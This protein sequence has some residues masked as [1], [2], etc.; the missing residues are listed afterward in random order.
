M[1]GLGDPN[2]DATAHAVIL[3]HK[4]YQPTRLVSVSQFVTTATAELWATWRR[5]IATMADVKTLVL[6][7]Y[8]LDTCFAWL[9]FVAR[10]EGR[11]VSAATAFDEAAWVSYVTAWEQGKFIDVAV[12]TSPA[13]LFTQLSHALLPKPEEDPGPGFVRSLAV[14]Q[15]LLD[16][17]PAPP[18][19]GIP[20]SFD[21]ELHR[22]AVA[23]I[24]FER[25]Q[26][27]AALERG[28]TFQLLLPSSVGDRTIIVDALAL[29][30]VE[31]TEILKT[32]ARQ[33][34]E[35]SWTRRGFTL[36]ALYR[37][38]QLHGN[39]MTVSVDPARYVTLQA[40]WARL[41]AMEDD[42]WGSDRPRDRPRRLESYKD[43]LGAVKAGAPNEPWY[44]EDARYTLIAAP[45]G[46]GSRLDWY[47]DVLP[48]SWDLY[49]LRHVR[50]RVR[51]DRQGDHAGKNITVAVWLSADAT[52]SSEVESQQLLLDAPS[53][54]AWL[55]A[56]SMYESDRSVRRPTQLPGAQEFDRVTYDGGFAVVSRKGVTLFHETGPAIAD[57]LVEVAE[58]VAEAVRPY[59][60]FLERYSRR[61]S[62]WVGQLQGSGGSDGDPTWNVEDWEQEMSAAR[63][64]TTKRR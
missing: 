7:D 55:A 61:L 20:P 23:Q 32:L 57:D 49:F 48:A 41:E 29:E 5:R 31:P 33:D 6:E 11:S 43:P 18:A 42:R 52:V 12:E 34:H 59:S 39:D 28:K 25:Q 44:D 60:A 58:S 9:A 16:T 26:Y 46:E 56:C 50:D 36:L 63:A 14:L 13:A 35:H 51:F 10:M 8:S 38:S 64:Q 4:G 21:S 30:E 53:F 19:A 47:E 15:E 27:A 54:S 1:I 40:L 45:R 17:F 24:D 22:Q 2:P 37:P 3:L 62:I